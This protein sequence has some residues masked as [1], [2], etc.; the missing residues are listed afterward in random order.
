MFL[1]GVRCEWKGRSSGESRKDS[2][3]NTQGCILSLDAEPACSAQS[4][5]RLQDERRAPP[6]IVV[7]SRQP[8]GW[9]LESG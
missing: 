5:V 3:A 9:T 1:A 4:R 2:T 8:H 7:C 6:T